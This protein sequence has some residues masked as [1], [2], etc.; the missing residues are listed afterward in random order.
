MFMSSDHRD[1]RTIRFFLH[2][3]N[4]KFAPSLALLKHE[5]NKRGFI[6]GGIQRW[7]VTN[8]V[9]LIHRYSYLS[10]LE[11]VVGFRKLRSFQGT[12]VNLSVLLEKLEIT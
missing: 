8:V 11:I 4:Q 3:K 9:T 2:L 12:Q 7:P 10:S 6:F 1:I 5:L